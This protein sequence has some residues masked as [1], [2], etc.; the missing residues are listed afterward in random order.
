MVYRDIYLTR[1]FFSFLPVQ[2]A[3]IPALLESADNGF[4]VGRGGY[5]PSDLCVSAPTGS[6]KTLAFVIPVVQV[7]LRAQICSRSMMGGSQWHRW[8][9]SLQALL[10][11]VVCHIRALVVLPTKELAQ[12]VCQLCIQKFLSPASVALRVH[13]PYLLTSCPQLQLPC[14]FMY[15]SL[16]QLYPTQVSAVAGD[17]TYLRPVTDSFFR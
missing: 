13:A 15:L 12:Q 7:S 6:G 8:S 17:T 5:Q 9:L 1:S 10:H 3:V 11:R 2:A 14:V 16:D 4:L